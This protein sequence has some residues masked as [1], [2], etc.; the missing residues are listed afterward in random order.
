MRRSRLLYTAIVRPI[1]TYGSE[2]WS[3][4]ANGSPIARSATERLERLQTARLR[5][6]TGAYRATNTKAIQR[7]AGVL[8]LRLWMGNQSFQHAASTTKLPV[9]AKPQQVLRDIAAT[10]RRRRRGLG[11]AP[12]Q[13]QTLATRKLAAEVKEEIREWQTFTAESQARHAQRRRGGRGGEKPKR[14][15]PLTVFGQ[16]AELKW[17]REWAECARQRREKAS[18]W[19]NPWKQWPQHLYDGLTK[20]EGTALFLLLTETIGLNRW[21]A[22]RGVPGVAK[23][24]P[25]GWNDQTVYHIIFHCP[26][27]DRSTL[28]QRLSSE[29]LAT[30]LSHPEQARATARWF[31]Q[32]DILEQFRVA[33]AIGEERE[34]GAY[35]GYAPFD[36][37]SQW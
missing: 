27:Y 8:P 4:R 2:I 33:R 19:R 9:E 17:H 32:Q 11:A 16:W 34:R 1:I 24:C 36:G 30:V 25:C 31:V 14:T 35:E 37:L 10:T 23:R 13:S 28:L 3:R 7:E 21:L 26:R 29:N 15:K 18:T 20:A 12:P 22:Q 5:R 6:V